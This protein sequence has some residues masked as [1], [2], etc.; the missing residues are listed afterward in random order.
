MGAG[1]DI[2]ARADQGADQDQDDRQRHQQF[3]QRKTA[4]SWILHH[5]F[6]RTFTGSIF[7][8]KFTKDTKFFIYTFFFV[9]FARRARARRGRCPSWLNRCASVHLSKD[10]TL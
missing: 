9:L 7:T 3:H 2:A 5:E 8:T 10:K 1:P 6:T 4:L